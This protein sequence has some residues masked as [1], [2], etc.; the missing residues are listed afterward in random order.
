MS[1]EFSTEN[2]NKYYS[3]SSFLRDMKRKGEFKQHVAKKKIRVY[4]GVV[5]GTISP[6]IEV[7]IDAT[8]VSDYDV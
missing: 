6:D 8:R 7:H 3:G 5:P 2:V 4:A 1:R